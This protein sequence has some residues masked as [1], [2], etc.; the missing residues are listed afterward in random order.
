MFGH[1]RALRCAQI[2]EDL[3]S[4]ETSLTQTQPCALGG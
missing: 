4:V 2:S 1:A 3:H